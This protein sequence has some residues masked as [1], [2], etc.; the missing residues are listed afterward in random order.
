M[1]HRGDI[2]LA[3]RTGKLV[4]AAAPSVGLLIAARDKRQAA[5]WSG[6]R[7]HHTPVPRTGSYTL[8]PPPRIFLTTATASRTRFP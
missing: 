3:T 5:S 1:S 6:R 4:A 7:P 8:V 2:A